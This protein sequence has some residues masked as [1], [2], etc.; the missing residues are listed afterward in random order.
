[1]LENKLLNPIEQIKAVDFDKLDEICQEIR[2]KL[3]L[4]IS[5]NGGH[6]ASNLGVVELTVAL[7]KVFDSPIDQLVWDVSHQSYTHKLLTGRAEL[8]DTI[9]QYGGIS[10]YTK[11]SESPHDA[12]GAGHSSTSISAALGMAKAKTMKG[13]PGYTIA[14]IGDGAFTG[15]MA[16]EAIN[17]A[18]RGNDKIII[19]L[20]DN[21]MSISQ[22]V[23]SMAKYLAEIRNMPTY[24]HIKDTTENILIHIPLIGKFL[25]Q[26]L[27]FTKKVIKDYFFHSNFF[28]NMGLTYLGPVDGHNIRAMTKV[29]NRAKELNKPVIVHVLTVKGKGYTHAENMPDKFHGIAEFDIDTGDPVSLKGEGFSAVFG[30]KLKELAE[31]DSR[32]CAVSAAMVSGTGLQDFN[33]SRLYDVGIAEPHAVT[34]AAGMAKNGMLPVCAVYSSFLQRAYDQIV[35][36]VCLQNLKVIFAIDRAGIVGADGE[37]HQGVFDVG[38][39]NAIPNMTIFSPA[40]YM[41][42]END[43]KSAFYECNGPVAVRYPKGSEVILPKDF[44]SQKTDFD[45]YGENTAKILIVTYGRLFGQA[46]IAKQKL[47][48]NG[49]EV[50]ILKLNKIKP[51]DSACFENINRYENILFFEEGMIS[52]GIGE[53]FGAKLSDYQG[54]YKIFGIDDIFVPHGSL[55]KL[56][57]VLGLDAQGMIKSIKQECNL[58][59]D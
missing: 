33:K 6:L 50:M 21:E 53:H 38:F 30:K 15:G 5:K 42:L 43:L 27:V 18:G 23:G 36:D 8:F 48:Q 14:I 11:I 12:F 47:K 25:N 9:R 32:I 40:T 3:I 28:E 19:V 55:S 16:Y 31:I 10:G 17:N 20:N 39:L 52:S 13:E 22:N 59:C 45:F 26:F 58:I 57:S 34:F 44:C 46:V 54:E 49:I 29:F 7:H 4:T 51:I 56:L 41:E 2:E 35:H 37:T 1:M 24:F